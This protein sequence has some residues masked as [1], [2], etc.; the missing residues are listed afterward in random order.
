MNFHHH[1]PTRASRRVAATVLATCG[2][3]CITACSS[4]S[5]DSETTTEA[6]ASSTPDKSATT[7]ATDNGDGFAALT[8]SRSEMSE[9][10][11][12]DIE[13]RTTDSADGIEASR[14]PADRDASGERITA[15]VHC[16]DG[17]GE[18][19]FQNGDTGD[20]FVRATVEHSVGD[21]EPV[22]IPLG[23]SSSRLLVHSPAGSLC[24]TEFTDTHSDD[25]SQRKI[26]VT[27]H[28][29]ESISD[30]TIKTPPQ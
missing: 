12:G 28:D 1:I 19:L 30:T 2:A 16:T 9:S 14:Q 6:A 24:R 13:Q 15:F 26:A 11:W 3:V 27:D 8:T 17:D 18:V 5:S 29:S 22:M 10:A 25:P 23:D 7:G 21:G 4:P 20:G